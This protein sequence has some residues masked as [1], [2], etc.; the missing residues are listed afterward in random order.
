VVS[1]GKVIVKITQLVD[2]R[3]KNAC[4]HAILMTAKSSLISSLNSNSME[5]SFRSSEGDSH[6]ADQEIPRLL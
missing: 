2:D 3:N 5:H 1:S 6:S 4:M